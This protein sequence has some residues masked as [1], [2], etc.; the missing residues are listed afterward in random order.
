MTNVRSFASADISASRSPPPSSK[1]E[2]D[3]LREIV[4]GLPNAIAYV[5]P[6]DTMRLAN[7]AY[8]T[9][10][11]CERSDIAPLTSTEA[12]L[13]WQFETGRQPL[14]HPTVAESVASALARQTEADGTP[15]IREFLGRIYEHRFIALP[16]GRTMTVYHDITALKQQE[17]E[18]RSALAYA[19]A[20]NDV[21]KVISRSTFD[22]PTILTTVVGKAL[23]L[24]GAEHGI[25]YRYHD[26]ACHFEVGCNVPPG[27]D[28]VPG[29]QPIFPASPT[30]VGRALR[31][32]R[33][34]QLVE[35]NAAPG[36][37]GKGHA[38]TGSVRSLLGVPLLRDGEPIGVL[39]LARSTVSAFTDRQ[40]EM[41]TGFAD[42]AAIAIENARLLRELQDAREEAERERTMMRSVLDNVSDGIGL[43]EADGTIALRNNAMYEINSYPKALFE[44]FAN[45]K[46]SVRYQVE[47]GYIP[48]EHD[49]VEEEIEAAFHRF[50][51]HDATSLTR[52]RPN[53]RWVEVRWST[54]PDGRRLSTHHDITDLKQR[55][56]ALTERT[57]DLQEALEFQ[58]AVGDA[59]R[60]ISHSGFD[61]NTVLKTVLARARVLFGA[62][63]AAIYRFQN[64][65]YR[66]NIGLGLS[67]EYEA[68]ERSGSHPPDR[69]TVVGRAI[70]DRRPVLIEDA[71][72]DPTYT[73]AA[74]AR[75]GN[76]RTVLGV[77]LMRDGVPIGA[78]GLARSSVR[79]FT[80]RQIERVS[81]FADQ[82]AIAIESA[83]LFE[84]QQA[85]Q[86][87]SERDRGLMRAILDNLT[88][89]MALCE[90][91]GTITLANEAIREINGWPP[92]DFAAFR[93]VRDGIAWQLRHGHLT[94]T[95]SRIEADVERIMAAYEAGSLQRPA[96]LRPN[97][98][99]VEVQWR[100]LADGRRLIVHRDVTELKKG[101]LELKAAS[102]ALKL[103]G[104]K[105]AA[106]LDHMPDAVSLFASNGDVLHL[107]PAAHAMDQLPTDIDATLH[108]MRDR[109]RWQLSNRPV[110]RQYD[111][112]DDE[113]DTRMAIFFDENQHQEQQHLFGKWLDVHW[114]PLPDGRRLIVQ[115]DITALKEQELRIAEERDAAER[116]RAEAEAANQAKSTF[117]ATMSHEIRTP[118]NGVLGMMEVLEHQQMTAE[119]RDTVG[120]MRE[121]AVSLLRIIDDVLDFSKIEAGRMTLEETAFSLSD[122]VTGTIQTLRPQATAKGIRMAAA[123]DPGSA[124][125]L[126]GDPTRVRQILFNLLGNAVKFTEKGSIHVRAGTE[127]LGDG[128]QRIALTVRDTGIGMDAA[129]QAHLFQPFAQADSS[130]TRRFGGTGLGLSI[131]RRLAQ[132]MDGD[133]AVDSA[134]GQGAT[135]TVTLLLH[136]APAIEQATAPDR[137]VGVLSANGGTL[138]VV[139][140]HP[141]NREVL[142][143]QLGLLGL[144][145][146]TA[147][148]GLS[149]LAMW[150]PGRYIAI[151]ADMHMPRMDGYGLTAEIR[152]REHMEGTTPTPIVAV[153]A[154]AMRGEEERCLAAGMDA[155]IAKPVSL[156]RLRETLLRWVAMDQRELALP[157]PARAGIDRTT[158]RHWVGEDAD[159]IAALV[160]R[161]IDSA[162]A[163]VHDIETEVRDGDLRAAATAAHKLK[164]AA[165]TLGAMT[166]GNI[167]ARIETLA[168]AGRR[169]ACAAALEEIGAEMRAVA[170]SA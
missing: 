150:R 37:F 72:N 142:V 56:I 9:A 59:L 81:T 88:D 124:D 5:D 158:L 17:N 148:D 55:E 101:E 149:A 144:T 49:S 53:G 23:E 14:T 60:V 162:Q 107:N 25:L 68:L 108:N 7:D 130:T 167:A 44:T 132:L 57:G 1:Q 89:G 100:V 73:A 94:Q 41:V 39:A 165:L 36:R 33:A 16:E 154:N 31:E 146:E 155:Y 169:A 129:Q 140:D 92:D 93:N 21:L 46:E 78:I 11:G 98:R 32:R 80:E 13:R 69:G 113:L 2:A 38:A 115:R 26:G 71:W 133:V 117:L 67:T 151:L 157:S 166:L 125:A 24:C 3:I 48:R 91:D 104:E 128:R 70:L 66:F 95:D 45:I 99:W 102:E 54:L 4:L 87:E 50:Q 34:V 85:A 138:L 74:E 27:Y 136:A 20:M 86:R 51:I 52:Y 83:R 143:R 147:E 111:D 120:I 15:V 8:L 6:D 64:G 164:G 42:Q 61:L 141:V 160:K 22:L 153:T 65:S 96:S 75:I 168:K 145:A 163:S 103:E 131:V 152:S 63:V 116:A 119:Q 84:K 62:D 127:P 118:M 126:I 105:L 122:I 28:G 10:M 90:A 77:P 134:P 76:V 110:P 43:Y 47:N 79:P 29:N 97:G 170:E 109:F 35:T 18:L 40:I 156:A 121:S 161:F 137:P 112:V 159:A 106:I 58:S 135:F 114:L 139:D 12:R 30:I 82:A 19:A 123:I